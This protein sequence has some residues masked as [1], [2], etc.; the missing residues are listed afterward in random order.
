[1]V[2]TENSV[3]LS[4]LSLFCFYSEPATGERKNGSTAVAEAVAR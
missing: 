1:M 3:S 4:F 2:L